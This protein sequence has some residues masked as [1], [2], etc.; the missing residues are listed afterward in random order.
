MG[1]KRRQ[2][3]RLRSVG[4]AVAGEVI[5]LGG[6]GDAVVRLPSGQRVMAAGGAPGDVVTLQQTAKRAGVMRGQII[7]VKTPGDARV[8]PFCAVAGRCGGCPWQHVTVEE[9]RHQKRL[10]ARRAIG[11][12]ALTVP[13]VGEQ[14]SQR[15]RR[16][17]R[18]HLRQ[19]HGHL[20][21]GFLAPRSHDLVATDRCPVLVE[22]LEA[23]MGPLARWLNGL[24]VRAEIAA[25]AGVEGVVA[26]IH[27]KP[28]HDA[29]TPP[30]NQ[31]TL[32]ELGLIGL[33]LHFGRTTVRHGATEVTLVETRTSAQIKCSARGFCQ[34][35]SEANAAIREATASLLDQIEP[36]Q[37]AAE[38]F[39][40]SG[41]LSFLLAG[42]AKHVT[43]VEL[44][45]GAVIRAKDT[46]RQ[47]SDDLLS[48]TVFALHHDDA[49][50]FAAKMRPADLWLLDPGRPGAKELIEHA[51]VNGPR[52]I[53]YVSCAFDT[54]G[55]D[56]KRLQT[57]GYAIVTAKLIDTFVHTPHF[58]IAVLLSRS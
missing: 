3:T 10:L 35:G 33:A 58:E 44:D 47:S 28:R 38:F 29:I 51:A 40:G 26:E 7:A 13:W 50:Q 11:D 5:G 55:R 21:P 42:R 52:H 16:R 54:L 20:R 36:V 56:L 27:A 22:Q 30:L 18:A 43:T 6:R 34:G 41:N 4:P 24:V 32:D 57:F 12:L 25:V 1:R 31:Q 48:Q 45:E 8:D 23:I 53:L 14:P 19:V 49:A 39:S 17:L 2:V 9:Q 15:W 37:S 46:L